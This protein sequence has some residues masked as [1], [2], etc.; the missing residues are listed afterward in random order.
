MTR[1]LPMYTAHFGLAAAPFAITPDPRF[2]FESDR[3]REGLAHLLYGIRQP[4]G[5]VQLTGE[6]GTGKTTLCRC[7]LEQLPPDVDVALILNPQVTPL[8]FLASLCDEL[9]IFYPAGGQSLKLLVDALHRYLLNAHARGRRTVLIVDEAQSLP[10]SVLEQIRLLTNLETATQKLLQILLIG[11]PELIRM[12]ERP[13]LRQL[14]QRITARYHLRPFAARDTAAY[15]VHR[16]R[17]SGAADRVFTSPALYLVHCRSGGIPRLINVICDRALLGAY[18]EDARRIT[19]RTVRRAAREVRGERPRPPW[20][21]RLAWTA[22]VLLAAGGLA[23]G[24]YLTATRWRSPDPPGAPPVADTPRAERRL[25]P[26]HRPSR[27]ADPTRPPIPGDRRRQDRGPASPL[28]PGAGGAEA[29]RS[30]ARR[31]SA[32]TR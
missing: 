3:H 17:V 10:P 18:A 28:S 1:W 21:A 31:P 5:F 27:G 29:E 22:A 24:G 16:L 2:F 6:V 30:R 23:F 12:L 7:L 8:E 26:H 20:G 32:M 11:Q 14:A 15:V 9:R 25:R 13:L 19:A 4:G